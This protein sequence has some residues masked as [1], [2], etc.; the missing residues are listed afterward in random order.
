MLTSFHDSNY[1]LNNKIQYIQLEDLNE[2]ID[3]QPYN[4]LNNDVS[5]IF[6]SPSYPDIK[7]S[8]NINVNRVFP[9]ID[10]IIIKPT[11]VDD[12]IVIKDGIVLL[13]D[14]SL[15]AF[16]YIPK[17][18]ITISLESIKNDYILP[19]DCTFILVLCGVLIPPSSGDYIKLNSYDKL[20]INF[21]KLTQTILK[22]KTKTDIENDPN[23]F[24]IKVPTP[25]IVEESYEDIYDDKFVF[26]KYNEHNYIDPSNTLWFTV[27]GKLCK[28]VCMKDRFKFR[29][30]PRNFFHDESYIYSKDYSDHI[31]SIKRI[32][33]S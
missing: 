7:I 3:I 24:L 21:N 19:Q 28:P 14:H 31:H 16:L 11:L 29:I 2:S 1:N 9:I 33:F 6:D 17:D 4:I 22:G 32:M 13:R 25:F 12:F 23:S 20:V 30:L 15:E 10:G 8:S 18:S 27:D 26:K 5:D